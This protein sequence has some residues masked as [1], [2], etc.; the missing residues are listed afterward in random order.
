MKKRFFK[1]IL[2]ILLGV[3][4]I[5][6]KDS[7]SLNSG[8]ASIE[9]TT[10]RGIEGASVPRQ[11]TFL[12]NGVLRLTWSGVSGNDPQNNDNGTWSQ[13]GKN[14]YFQFN[15]KHVQNNGNLA[16]EKMTGETVYATGSKAK[17]ELQIINPSVESSFHE[18]QE[19]MRS[20]SNSAKNELLKSKC[21]DVSTVAPDSY[22]LVAG[23]LKISMNSVGFIKTKLTYRESCLIVVDTPKGQEVC[24]VENIL[25]NNSSAEYIAV[26]RNSISGA[27]SCGSWLGY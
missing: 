20:A 11:Y 16:G 21:L 19:K 25:Y 23:A 15:D 7:N 6:C 26:L 2:A 3:N 22:E 24:K 4:L 5:S 8:L 1:L 12:P 9:G 18:Y 14:I 10:W 13:N 17:F 27:A